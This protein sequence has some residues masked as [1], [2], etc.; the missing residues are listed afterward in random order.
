MAKK[1]AA[2]KSVGTQYGERLIKDGIITPEEL[3]GWQEE[4]KANLYAIYD[5]TQRA[6][7]PSNCTR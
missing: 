3:A 6:R 4:Q 1:I 7:K 2:H 5:Q